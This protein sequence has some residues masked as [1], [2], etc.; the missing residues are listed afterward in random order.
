MRTFAT[1]TFIILGTMISYAQPTALPGKFVH[2]VYFWL[3]N[4]DNPSDRE[5]F[6]KHL[7]AF[8]SSSKYATSYHIAPPAGTPREVVDNSYTYNLVVTFE[9]AELQDLYQKED[10]HLKFVEDASHL[11]D[12]VQIYD[13]YPGMALPSAFERPDIQVGVV[14]S[15]LERSV[16]FYTNVLGM[17]KTGGFS[18]NEDFAKRSGL[19]NGVPFD[20]A[21]LKTSNS[22]AASEWKLMSFGKES[23]DNGSFIQDRTGMRY[24]TL[25]PGDLDLVIE[26]LKSAGVEFLGDT[27]TGLDDGRRFVLIRDP[28]GTLVELLGD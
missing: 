26:R 11:W 20:V 25:F 9:S 7:T 22:P 27:P 8:I 14:V 19:S 17:V 21:V 24:I 23:S 28:D 3:K 16:D 6:L 4:P 18:I 12:R 2:S 13:S 1:L 5:E 15:N 10:V